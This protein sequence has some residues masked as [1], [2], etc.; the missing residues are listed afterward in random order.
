MTNFFMLYLIFFIVFWGKKSHIV[1][2][3][4]H[5]YECNNALDAH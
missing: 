2:Y 1:C 3:E 4:E 5:L